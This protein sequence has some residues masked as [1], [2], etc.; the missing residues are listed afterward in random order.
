MIASLLQLILALIEYIAEEILRLIKIILRNVLAL[1]KAFSHK[2]SAGVLA[3]ANKL[4]SILCMFQNL[5]VLFA[6]FNIIIQVIKDILSL[7]FAI[8]PCDDGNADGCCTTD[9]CPSIVKQEYTRN[10][11]TFRYLPKMDITSTALGL[12]AEFASL[13]VFNVRNE[14]WQLFDDQ[15]EQQEQFRNIFDGYDVTVSPKPIFFPTDANYSEKTDY[16]QAPYVVDLRMLYNPA[17]W[18]RTGL[19]RYIQFKNCIITQVPSVNLINGDTSATYIYNAV[20]TLAGGSGYEDDGTTALNGYNAD[21]ITLNAA[22]NATLENFIHMPDMVSVNPIPS[23]TD[24]YT[25]SDITYTFRPN[26]APL[27]QKNLVTAGCVP[28]LALNRSFVN[29]VLSGDIGLKSVLLT[30]LVTSPSFPDPA[31]AQ[32]CLTNAITDLRLNMTAEGVALFQTTT[33]ICLQTLKDNTNNALGSLIGIGFDPCKSSFTATPTTQFTSQPI[34]VSVS[35]NERNG[36]PLA[37]GINS[38]VSTNLA[39]RLK[40]HTTFGSIDNFVYDGY[41]YFNANLTSNSSGSGSIMVSFDNNVFCTNTMPPLGSA[42]SVT[43]THTLQSINY[44]FVYAPISSGDN[45]GKSRRDEVSLS[46]DDRGN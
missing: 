29:N 24:G 33:S 7:A 8:P 35:L 10:T 11:G 31:A 17:N 5:F 37:V 20:A 43:P 19:T 45:D 38:N 3:I 23:V 28:S 32:E 2:D 36:L 30:D 25:F 34:I 46:I 42:G 39:V 15:Q 12:P 13:G 22:I 14:S 21:G 4:G 44:Q 6:L 41:Q 18:G 9:V 40:A 16:R 26:I 1:D 27:L